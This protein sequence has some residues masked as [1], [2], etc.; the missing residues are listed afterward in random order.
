MSR[1]QILIAVAIGAPWLGSALA[2]RFQ[3]HLRAIAFVAAFVSVAGSALLLRDAAAHEALKFFDWAYANGGKMAQDL[4]YI[5]MPA[6]VVAA[7]K[8]LW[9]SDIKDS[10]GKPIY[11]LSN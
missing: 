6:P 10:G 2:V 11:A 4:D 3:Q 1:N 9:A 7:I 5:P 8:K